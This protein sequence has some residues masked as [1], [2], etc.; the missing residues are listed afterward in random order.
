MIDGENGSDSKNVLEKKD[1]KNLKEKDKRKD[2]T[3]DDFCPLPNSKK[4]KQKALQNSNRN[5]IPN[6]IHQVVSFMFKKK[7]S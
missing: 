2:R 5:V 1:V 7:K 4:K 6:I 3:D